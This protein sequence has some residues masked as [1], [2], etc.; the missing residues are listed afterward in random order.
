MS[1][2]NRQYAYFSITGSFDPEEI[3]R[4]AG[5]E[6][7]DAWRKGDKHPTNGLERRFS[8]WSLRSRLPEESELEVHVADVLEQLDLRSEAFDAL[9]NEYG[10]RMQL[11]G[12]FHTHY[13]GLYFERSV[14]QRLAKYHLE[15]DC[16]FYY[17]FSNAREDT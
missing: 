2:T 11:V 5:I 4:R 12:Y 15:M 6:P 8:R 13:P 9:S 16:D 14:V 7:S 17:L 1:E 10:G 3:T